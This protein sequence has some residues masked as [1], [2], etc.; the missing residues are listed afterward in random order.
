MLPYSSSRM[1]FGI[2]V[3][4]INKSL[5][6]YTKALGLTEVEGFDVPSDMGK[7]SGLCDGKPF[8]VHIVKV[9]DTDDA[10]NIK[11]MQFKDAPGARQDTTF[12][13][14]TLGVRYLTLYV[15]DMTPV[16]QQAAT[17]GVKPIAQGPVALPESLASG[18]YLAVLRDPDGNM[19]ELV[20]PKK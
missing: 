3:S 12:I 13:N 7:G 10:T 5:A 15:A 4:D 6:F 20:G 16:L 19:I 2:V 1:D 8:H 18:V 14:S 11:L 9:A 17:C